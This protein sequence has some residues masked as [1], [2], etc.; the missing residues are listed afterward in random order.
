MRLVFLE[1]C[2]LAMSHGRQCPLNAK[3][4]RGSGIIARSL[5]QSKFVHKFGGIL[6]FKEDELIALCKKIKKSFESR[7]V[8]VTR[9]LE[10][11]SPKSSRR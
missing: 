5:L 3:Q 4:V 11:I 9:N 7:V 1:W 8:T 6:N 2:S 10:Q